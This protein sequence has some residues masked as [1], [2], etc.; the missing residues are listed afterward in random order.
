[1]MHYEE[2]HQVLEVHSALM[3]PCFDCSHQDYLVQ[4]LNSLYSHSFRI[5]VDVVD[6][7]LYRY[8]T[9]MTMDLL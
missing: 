3:Y 5:S 2:V 4:E 9:M 7:V 6:T 1:M 8:R